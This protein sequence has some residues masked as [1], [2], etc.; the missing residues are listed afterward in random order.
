MPPSQLL[1]DR[2]ILGGVGGEWPG[3]SSPPPHPQPCRL[4]PDSSLAG[5]AQLASRLGD[6]RCVLAAA[7]GRPG[8]LCFMLDFMLD[9]MLED[10]E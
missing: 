1:D 9:F 8:R 7:P 5:G 2:R 6:G 3:I 4:E 10:E